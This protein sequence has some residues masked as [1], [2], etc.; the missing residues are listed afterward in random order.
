MFY[1][2][3][4]NRVHLCVKGSS[5]FYSFAI[6]M[7]CF[8]LHFEHVNALYI[9]IYTVLHTDEL[10]GEMSNQKSYTKWNVDSKAVRNLKRKKR[11]RDPKKEARVFMMCIHNIYIHI[12]YVCACV[13]T[14]V[15]TSLLIYCF[16][17]CTAQFQIY[18]WLNLL[19]KPHGW[20]SGWFFMTSWPDLS[21]ASPQ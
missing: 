4:T 17:R 3:P 16:T 9:Y 19:R 1:H 15:E 5:M 18:P 2:S 21:V 6:L 13:C 10:L 14:Y 11:N 12:T 7:G 20:Y 8:P